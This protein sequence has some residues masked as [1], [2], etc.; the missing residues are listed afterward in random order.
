M[1]IVKLNVGGQ[2]FITT[3]ETLENFPSMLCSLYQHSNPATLLDGYLFIDRDP[4]SFRWILNYLRGS[5]ILPPKNSPDIYLLLEE[6]QYFAVGGLVSRIGH[7]LNPMFTKGD[8]I[9]V[10]ATKFT[11]LEVQDSGYL[12]TRGGQKYRLDS[13]EQFQPTYIEKGDTITAYRHYKWKPGVCMSVSGSDC[14]IQLDNEQLDF[15]LSG[16]RF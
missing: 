14:D 11:I 13:S 1:T 7:M 3:N 2:L 16:V 15:K 9:S 10:R 8:H 6:A 5:T 12:A 4:H